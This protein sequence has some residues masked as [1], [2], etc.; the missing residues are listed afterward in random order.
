MLGLRYMRTRELFY[1][2]CGGL[3]LIFFVYRV[4]SQGVLPYLL[5]R[6]LF[7]KSQFIFKGTKY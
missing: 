3:N 1:F 7:P 6:C 5:N 4:M 2:F